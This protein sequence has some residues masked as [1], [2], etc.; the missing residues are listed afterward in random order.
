MTRLL[1]DVAAG[2]KLPSETT[3][4]FHKV[5]ERSPNKSHPALGQAGGNEHPDLF[6]EKAGHKTNNEKDD[7]LI[8]A[9]M[10]LKYAES[11]ACVG[12]G[13]ENGAVGAGP[14]ADS[15]AGMRC[16]VRPMQR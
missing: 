5:R 8:P 15:G 14:G 6:D 11:S 1:R 9:K 10:H 4:P 12:F 16:Q 7:N 3:A 2:S 13:F